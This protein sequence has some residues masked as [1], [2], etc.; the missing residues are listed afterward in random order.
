MQVFKTF[1][2]S[3]PQFWEAVTSPRVMASHRL[4]FGASFIAASV[5]TV[6]GLQPA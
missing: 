5:H 4:T 3:W 2:M 6:F 1:T